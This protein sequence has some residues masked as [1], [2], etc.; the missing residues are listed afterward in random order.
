MRIGYE[1]LTIPPHLQNYIREIKDGVVERPIPLGWEGIV[2]YHP[3]TNQ[4]YGTKSK[5]PAHYEEVIRTKTPRYYPDVALSLRK[6]LD[7]DNQYQFFVFAI[8]ARATV[9]GWLASI[10][11]RRAA[12]RM[13][14][15]AKVK[16]VMF[17]VT[18]QFNKFTRY[19][20][21]PSTATR[22]ELIKAANKGI[23]AWL[24]STASAHRHERATMQIALR[25]RMQVNKE[26]F[27]PTSEVFVDNDLNNLQHNQF[28]NHCANWNLV[29]VKDF[30]HKT[31]TG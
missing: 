25:S 3:A 24:Q 12:T 31:T 1:P 10:G 6:L 26:V 9:E 14:E 11:K 4:F 18:S 2:V 16:H 30:I 19:V 22:E 15:A 7:H 8:G 5:N 27:E 23:A 20:I 13:G 17:R 29:A 28:R 21:A